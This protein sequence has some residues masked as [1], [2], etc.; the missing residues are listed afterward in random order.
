ML[1]KILLQVLCFTTTKKASQPILTAYIS[2]RIYPLIFLFLTVINTEVDLEGQQNFYWRAILSIYK[3]KGIKC[4]PVKN[5]LPFWIRLCNIME[6]LK[7][8]SL[9]L[10][11]TDTFNNGNS[12]S[13][14]KSFK[15]FNYA[16]EFI[17]FA[18]PKAKPH[19]SLMSLCSL[20]VIR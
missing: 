11:Y 8:R 3:S 9:F 2:L 1:V 14:L 12:K 20:Y 13:I 15:W 5:L 19:K 17:R 18:T 6:R 7:L 4:S 10:V 16:V